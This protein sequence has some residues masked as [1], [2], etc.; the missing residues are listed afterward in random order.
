MEN[1][2]KTKLKYSK[3]FLVTIVVLGVVLS[4]L[5]RLS[6]SSPYNAVIDKNL[7]LE[8]GNSYEV[9]NGHYN[10]PST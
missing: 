10:P 5:P 3:T 8:D 7:L 1:R 6:L 9:I 4:T 2:R